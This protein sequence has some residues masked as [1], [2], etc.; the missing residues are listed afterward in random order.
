MGLGSSFLSIVL[1]GL[2]LGAPPAETLPPP[3]R[4]LAGWREG[5]E[6]LGRLLLQA[7]EEEA[8]PLAPRPLTLE[9]A[10]QGLTPRER[11]RV[12]EGLRRVLDL[13]GFSLRPG[14]KADLRLQ[15]RRTGRDRGRFTL[16]APAW[17][18]GPWTAEIRH[19]PWMG[20]PSPGRDGFRV[21]GS[22][23]TSPAEALASARKEAARRLRAGLA[24]RL[25]WRPWR[26]AFL[27]GLS[28]EENEIDSF[29]EER[30]REGEEIWRGWVLWRK[31]E[32]VRR[33]AALRLRR[34]DL[35]WLLRLSLAVAAG[36]GLWLVSVRLDWATKGFFTG[37]IRILAFLAWFGAC[38]ALWLVV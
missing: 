29:L 7:M 6:A 35:R 4:V 19:L 20:S 31:G 18:L 5:G 14:G 26:K 2:P 24:A 28:L 11:S 27:E 38:G 25:P 15:G 36:L 32:E 22:W 33:R 21:S 9:T 17:G 37:R 10:F 23:E 3:R 8:L 34:E 13:R 1:A 30:G 12:L 16:E